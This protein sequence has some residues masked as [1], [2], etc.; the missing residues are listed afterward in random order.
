MIDNPLPFCVHLAEISSEIIM[1]QFTDNIQVKDKSTGGL[2][3]VTATDYELENTIKQTIL[4]KY[5]NHGFWAEENGG[6]FKEY[7]WV[8][9]PLDGTNNFGIGLAIAGTS[10]TLLKNNTPIIGIITY[11]FTRTYFIG[12]KGQGVYKNRLVEKYYLPKKFN[13][14]KR[15]A[16]TIGNP[17][18]SSAKEHRI[19]L[20]KKLLLESNFNRVLDM[21]C[22]VAGFYLLFTGALSGFIAYKNEYYDLLAGYVIGKELGLHIVEFDGNPYSYKMGD[23]QSFIM[24]RLANQELI[25]KLLTILEG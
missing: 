3:I 24:T 8:V 6:E 16:T 7:T 22:P 20:N 1:S 23:Y 12:I 4:G 18:A 10:I 11:P 14:K 17:I 2:D 5:P 9:D 21:W 15:I 25:E 19:W 13:D